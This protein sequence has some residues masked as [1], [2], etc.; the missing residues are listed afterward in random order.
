MDASHGTG[1]DH[2]D[3]CRGQP[4]STGSMGRYDVKDLISSITRGQ[5]RQLMTDS[6]VAAIGAAFHDAGFA[7]NPD[8]TYDDSSVRRS[9]PG[10]P[11]SRRLV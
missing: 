11:G 10:V 6:T 1:D 4:A 9:H 7:P 8:S 5:F 2:C 3:T